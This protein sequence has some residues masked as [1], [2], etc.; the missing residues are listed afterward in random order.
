MS[1]F[2]KDCPQCTA[3][4]AANA[5]RC[6]CGYFFVPE[7]EA[8]PELSPELRAQEEKLYEAYLAARRN[9]TAEALTAARVA[10]A[11]VPGNAQAAE[12]LAE[13]EAALNAAE[14]ELD[15][16]KKKNSEARRLVEAAEATAEGL[17]T[18]STNS[19]TV[20]PA[21]EAILTPNSALTLAQDPDSIATKPAR[22]GAR[23]ADEAPFKTGK[24]ARITP[25]VVEQGPASARAKA[26][27]RAQVKAQKTARAALA[28]ARAEQIA[29]AEVD[30][31]AHQLAQAEEALRLAQT[32]EAFRL[33]KAKEALRL[34]QAEADDRSVQAA[35]V[36]VE[37]QQAAR[38][39]KEALTVS[40]AEQA[41]LIRHELAEQAF[42]AKQVAKAE[43]ALAAA[44]AEQLIGQTEAGA[45]FRAAQ[46]AR[47]AQI[48]ANVKAADSKECP[49]CT[50]TVALVVRACRCGFTFPMGSTE[51]PALTLSA[52]ELAE[53]FGTPPS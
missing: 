23:S 28:K 19:Q 15:T 41:Q 14:T 47:A 8:G 17:K 2:Y 5:I 6:G 34:A 42:R 32:K 3:T 27:A 31:R 1:I 50:A 4:H 39:D 9:Q 43:H 52:G 33:A 53:L 16:Q 18:T 20:E 12:L 21:A 40:I 36:Q 35:R 7:N 51:L 49:S 13:A 25:L 44:K 46:S 26:E 22:A 37:A 10:A 38:E 30:S 45:A 11:R 48:V 29:K 24:T